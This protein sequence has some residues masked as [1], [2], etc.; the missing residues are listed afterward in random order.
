MDV[1]KTC[2]TNDCNLEWYDTLNTTTHVENVITSNI[3]DSKMWEEKIR[4]KI[5]SVLESRTSLTSVQC[6]FHCRQTTLSETI[7]TY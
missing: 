5:Y 4:A 1:K 2:S 3:R 7:A 6:G